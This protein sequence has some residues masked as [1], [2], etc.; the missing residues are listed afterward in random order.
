MGV[1]QGDHRGSEWYHK[2]Q[3]K[4]LANKYKNRH[5][6]TSNHSPPETR[7]KF[8]EDFFVFFQ[9]N[10]AIKEF[11]TQIHSVR[12]EMLQMT[13]K[14]RQILQILRKEKNQMKDM[15]RK[16]DMAILNAKFKL[17]EKK[18]ANDQLIV[19]FI[20]IAVAAGIAGL[21]YLFA[22]GTLL[23]NFQNKITTLINN[24]FNHA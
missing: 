1:G 11:S 6:M 10:L 24:W 2:N 22:T 23:P 7:K 5:L 9:L 15:I 8:L 4:T 13:F 16:M 21:V 19:M 18:E 20:I 17:R 14:A 12:N 3:I